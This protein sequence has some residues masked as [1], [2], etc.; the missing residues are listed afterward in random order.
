MFKSVDSA[1]VKI[2]LFEI[3]IFVACLFIDYH[4]VMKTLTEMIYILG[5]ITIITIMIEIILLFIGAG[6]VCGKMIWDEY[7]S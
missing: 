4:H 7:K 3:M 6:L 1:V 5:A 2:L